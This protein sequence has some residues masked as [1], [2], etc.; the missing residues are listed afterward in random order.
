LIG[1]YEYMKRKWIYDSIMDG[2]VIIKKTRIIKFVLRVRY[3]SPEKYKKSTFD[4]Y[5]NGS[6]QNNY[7]GFDMY[8]LT[9]DDEKK[10]KSKKY[11]NWDVVLVGDDITLYDRQW[12]NTWLTIKWKKFSIWDEIDVYVDPKHKRNYIMDVDYIPREKKSRVFK[13]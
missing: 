1:V 10:Y 12:P 8:F 5:V 7:D 9:S 4:R 13:E 11:Y 3:S 2:T 6:M